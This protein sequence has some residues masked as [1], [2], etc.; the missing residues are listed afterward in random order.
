MNTAVPHVRLSRIHI[1]LLIHLSLNQGLYAS[2]MA[3]S[4][5]EFVQMEPLWDKAI[6]FPEEISLDE[7]HQVMDWPP[8]E[9]MQSNTHKYLSLSV[10]DLFQKAAR[11]PDS[12]S[13]PECRMLRDCFRILRGDDLY[14][15]RDRWRFFL[16][17]PALDAKKKQADAA[18]LT[19]DELQALRNLGN[20][21]F[22]KEVKKLSEMQAKRKAESQLRCPF[23]PKE[24]VE[25]FIDNNRWGYVLYRYRALDG[26]EDLKALLDGVLA[27]P[28]YALDGYEKIHD[29]NVVEYVELE[30][31]ADGEEELRFLR[32]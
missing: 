13:Y 29:S 2:E 18:I 19:S 1:H 32:Q 30:P 21:F 27:M 5:E 20:V 7:K 28:L 24:W 6:Q 3:K 25:K 23:A 11:S 9:E 4:L 15:V 14:P 22:E 26:W 10:E 12:L 17:R 16:R 8:L 31:K